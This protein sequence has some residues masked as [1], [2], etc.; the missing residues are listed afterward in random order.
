MADIYWPAVTDDP[1]REGY[2]WQLSETLAV[3]QTGSGQERVAASLSGAD[4]VMT[5]GYPMSKWQ[6]EGVWL[7]WWLAKRQAGGCENGTPFWLRCP[8]LRR[9]LLWARK[10]GEAMR[11]E[12]DGLGKIV[13]LTLI[14]RLT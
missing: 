14:G 8:E 4:V 6:F 2:S 1:L 5:A 9:P 10:H 7:P 11:H 3:A 12:R 13:W